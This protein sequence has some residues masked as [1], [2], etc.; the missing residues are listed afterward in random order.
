MLDDSGAEEGGDGVEDA[1]V[2]PVRE[3]EEDE[4]GVGEQI[5]HGGE[6]GGVLT[7]LHSI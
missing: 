1:H 2:H 7:L 5:L 4:A 6:V 3:E